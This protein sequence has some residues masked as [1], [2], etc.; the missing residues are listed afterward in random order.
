MAEQRPFYHD[1]MRALQDQFDGRR[2]A[3]GLAAHRRRYD[4]WDDDRALIESAPF[5]FVA[6]SYGDYVDCSMRSGMP[7]FVKI[8]GPGTLE[9]PEYDGNSMYRTLGNISRNPNVGLLFVK[10]DGKTYRI[11][12]NGQATILDDADTLARHHAAKVVVRVVCELYSNCPR[13]VHD[14]ASGELSAYLPRRGYDTPAPEWKSRDYIR[15]I[16]PKDDP[17]RGRAR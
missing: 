15:D 5:F 14:L 6:T 12:V 1:G 2:V 17:H 10:F 7:G 9:Y 8:V 4:F 16:L 3:D 13:A 11:R